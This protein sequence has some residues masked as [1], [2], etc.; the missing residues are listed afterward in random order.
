MKISLPRLSAKDLATLAKRT[1]EVSNS[2]THAFLNNHPL[3]TELSARYDDYDAVYTKQTFS[4][5]GKDVAA[6]D[7]DRD[8]SFSKLKAFLNG[9]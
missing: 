3:L 1:L 6:A 9:Y 5:K 7:H 2:G 8:L 4:G